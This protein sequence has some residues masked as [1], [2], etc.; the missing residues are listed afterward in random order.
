MLTTAQVERTDQKSVKVYFRQGSSIIDEG[1]MNND[2][3]LHTFAKDVKAYIENENISFRKLRIV[4]GASPE[5]SKLIN[6][7]IANLRA[8]AITNWIGNE[9][10]S[11]LEYEVVNLGVDWESLISLIE[12][13]SD[14]PYRADVLN[15]LRNTPE[16]ITRN[17][18]NVSERYNRLYNLHNGEVYSWISR[19][20]FPQLRYASTYAE[21]WWNID[22]QLSITTASPINFTYEGGKGVISYNKNIDDNIIPSIKD[23]AEWI[24]SIE[25]GTNETTFNVTHNT[26]DKPRTATI[27]IN[28]YGKDYT[29]VVNQASEPKPEVVVNSTPNPQP[30]IVSE[31]SCKPFYMAIKTNLLY[32]AILIPN[33]G[34]E[35]YLGK[36]WSVAGNWHYSWWNDNKT[37]WYWRTYGGDVALR[38]WIGKRANQKPLTGHHLG[39]YGQMITYDFNFNDNGILADKWSYAAGLEYGY[40]LPVARR[41]NIDFTLGVGYHW[42]IYDEYTPID[43]HYVWQ[44]TKRRQYIGPTKLEVS[45]VWLLGCDN[46]NKGKGGRR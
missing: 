15:V 33:V 40:S 23:D 34:I 8:Q 1:Y 37:H 28:Y 41:L 38:K 18:Q 45:L 20:I 27:T 39:V 6:D 36:N 3:S 2:V 25:S 32:D 16:F 31:P 9:I 26:T 7:R 17:G 22:P 5:G 29:V 19:N 12:E 46:Y 35:F 13:R 24:N 44:A 43:G 21:V 11:D 30:E 42:G 4:A 14:V 10:S